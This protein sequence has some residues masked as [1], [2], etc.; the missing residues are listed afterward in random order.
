MKKFCSSLRKHGKKHNWFWK[1]T[2][3]TVNKRRTKITSR[4]KGLLH[5]WKKNLKKLSKSINYWKVR[6][7]CHYRG[8][9][10]GVTHSFCNLKF[11]VPNETP[12][13]CNFNGLNFNYHF[14]IK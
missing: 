12:V 1:G 2:N 10:G 5:L 8:K 14:I 7:H 11:N 4:L 3:V 6:G 13:F 9:Y